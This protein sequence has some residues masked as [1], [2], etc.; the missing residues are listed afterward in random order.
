MFNLAWLIGIKIRDKAKIGI[1]HHELERKREKPAQNIT[2]ET[3][4]KP[5]QMYT[6]NILI[7]L[8]LKFYIFNKFLINK[9]L[10]KF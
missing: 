1:M 5:Q 6:F 3:K 10:I 2:Q 9:F 4:I 7:F 8:I